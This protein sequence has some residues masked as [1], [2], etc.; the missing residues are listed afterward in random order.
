MRLLFLTTVAALSLSAL[1]VSAASDEEKAGKR[2][3]MTKSCLAC[4]GRNGAKPIMSFPALAGQNEKYLVQQMEDIRDGKRV[5]SVDPATGHPYVQGMTDIMHLL[6]PEDITNVS[7]YLAGLP[8][9]APE[10]LDP[11]PSAELLDDGAKA[12]KKLKCKTCHGAEGDKPTNK[13]YPFLAALDR[14]Y[15]IR[16][17][18]EMRDK[19]RTNGKSKMMWG[20]IKKADD[21]QIKAMAT[22]LSQVERPSK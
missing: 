9:A 14:D 4:H 13:A 21:E 5:G 3:Y 18:T 22:W 2:V 16:A 10:V 15:L 11:A 8:P 20:M 17:M 19:V 7:K 12:Y 1:S 6:S